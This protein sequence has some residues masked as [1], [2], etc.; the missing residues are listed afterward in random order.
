[1]DQKGEKRVS[2]GTLASPTVNRS[3]TN[4]VP[5]VCRGSHQR[6]QSST[7]GPSLCA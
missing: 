5:F 2:A 7:L 1:M 6:V 4:P 3:A